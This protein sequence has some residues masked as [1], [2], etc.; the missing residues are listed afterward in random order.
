MPS[1]VEGK[2]FMI[3]F[4]FRV[5]TVEMAQAKIKEF[6]DAVPDFEYSVKEYQVNGRTVFDVICDEIVEMRVVV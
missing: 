2:Q 1:R 3:A 4:I 5:T 6:I